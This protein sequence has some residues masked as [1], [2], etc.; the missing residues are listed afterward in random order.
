MSFS[1][2]DASAWNVLVV[3]EHLG[4]RSSSLGK[5]EREG[6]GRILL[7]F[8]K[9]SPLHPTGGNTINITSRTAST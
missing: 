1:D 9:S 4:G 3:E 5:R 8:G 6:T 2:E 7:C